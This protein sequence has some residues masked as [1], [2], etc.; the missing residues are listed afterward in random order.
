MQTAGVALMSSRLI[1]SVHLEI[2]LRVP[3]AEALDRISRQ[4]KDGEHIIRA[5]PPTA[6]RVS[7]LMRERAPW[8]E[9]NRQILYALF[10]TSDIANR[11]VTLTEA[12]WL[13]APSAEEEIIFWMGS[14]RHEIG[15]LHGVL[16]ALQQIPDAV[17]EGA[18]QQDAP[19]PAS[20]GTDVL[21]VH[22]GVA[23]AGALVA[24]YL[25]TLGL[26][27]S[28]LEREEHGSAIMARLDDAAVGF[29]AVLLA[30]DATEDSP[31]SA[32]EPTEHTEPSQEAVFGL[33]YALGKLG[34]NRV[35]ALKVGDVAEPSN[36]PGLHCVPLD[37]D[38]AWKFLLA[39]ELRTAGF[40]IT[41]RAATRGKTARK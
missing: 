38:D 15:Q 39:K 13:R 10:T 22:N 9:A 16:Q 17:A 2:E 26:T 29:A 5:G 12:T 14:V 19:D 30:A 34:E 1:R 4:I 31:T 28:V 3:R 25:Q 11:H 27:V 35:C 23:E 41:V 24:S 18:Q 37:S 36:M 8:S 7:I 40:A 21:V 33:G 20:R 32:E 6:E